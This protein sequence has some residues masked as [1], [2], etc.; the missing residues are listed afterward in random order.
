[1][2]DPEGWMMYHYTQAY[3]EGHPEGSSRRVIQKGHP[4]GSSR[5]V[6]QKGHPDEVSH[7]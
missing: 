3:H 2:D 1:M 6:I 4:E 5:R 7:M